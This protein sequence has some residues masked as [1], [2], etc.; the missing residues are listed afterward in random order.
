M[1]QNVPKTTKQW[2]VTS[3]DGKD[4][5]NALKLS[6][7]Q[8]SELGDSQVLVKRKSIGRLNEVI[9]GSSALTP[10]VRSPCRIAQCKSPGVA[11]QYATFLTAAV[12]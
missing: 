11:L 4:G 9:G 2:T 7:E 12:P 3:Q 5:F 10:F 1:A 6:E 8:L